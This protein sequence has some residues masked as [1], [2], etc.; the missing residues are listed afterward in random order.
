[1]TIQILLYIVV[2]L[3]GL[4][5][6]SFLNVCIYRIPKKEDIVKTR[7]HCMNCGHALQWYELVP[8]FS[9]VVLRGRCR[10]CKEKISIQYPL[11]EFTN[12]LG[13]VWIFFVNGIN[14]QSILYC[15]FTS[16]LIVISVIDSRTMEIPIGC[17]YFIAILGII[18][19]AIDFSNWK[20]YAIGAICVSAFLLMIYIV[21]GGRGIGGG[22]VKLMATAGLLVGAPKILLAFFIG[23]VLAACIHPI[24]MKVSKVDHQLAFGPYL[25]IGLYVSILYGKQIID[26]YLSTM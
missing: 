22:D 5:I 4:V 13:Y 21:T 7:S 8:V 24:R 6:G 18:Q 15:L 23:S 1:M 26:W 19:L 17:N 2:S 20:T 10:Q 12:A 25:C 11:V 3:F 14:I 16:T 9:Y